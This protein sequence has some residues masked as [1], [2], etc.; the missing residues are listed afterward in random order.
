MRKSTGQTTRDVVNHESVNGKGDASRVT[1]ECAY[2]KN[3]DAID[4]GH[5]EKVCDRARRII[6]EDYEWRMGLCI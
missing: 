4:W 3:F 5:V 6:E 1:D 2:R